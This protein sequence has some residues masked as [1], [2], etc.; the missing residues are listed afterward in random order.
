[1]FIFYAKVDYTIATEN[2]L[3]PDVKL[4]IHLISDEIETCAEEVAELIEQILAERDSE[5]ATPIQLV[6][7][8][9]E[10][11][12]SQWQVGVECDV[13][14]LRPLKLV[15][16]QLDE[17]AQKTKQDFVIGCI[18]QRTNKAEDVCYFGYHE[19]KAD[20]LEIAN[21]LNLKV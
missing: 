9:P 8:L 16:K 17:I 11:D 21:Y 19:G 14:R 4:Y 6:K 12:Y 7:S 10:D 15:F 18:N 5:N 1:M 3:Y 13:K 20:V 2:Q